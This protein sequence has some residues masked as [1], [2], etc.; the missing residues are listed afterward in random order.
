MQ[1]ELDAKGDFILDP[2][3]LAERFGLT[4][5]A[6]RRNLKLGFIKSTVE[7]GEGEDFG[8]SRLTLRLGN[9]KWQAIIGADGTV[10]SQ[11]MI[12]AK[13]G[14]NGNPPDGL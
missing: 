11:T 10:V 3:E 5:D 6:F 13:P 4:K 7:T 1:I 12:M 8:T 14:R 9:R 2:A